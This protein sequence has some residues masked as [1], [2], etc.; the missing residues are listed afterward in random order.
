[1]TETETYL[2]VGLFGALNPIHIDEI[3]CSKTR[4]K[5]P[6]AVGLLVNTLSVH[7][8]QNCI[9]LCPSVLTTLD[10]T[11]I[12]PVYF[13]DTIRADVEITEINE[14]ENIVS[15]KHEM[16]NQKEETILVGKISLRIIEERKNA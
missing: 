3:Y 12:A 1:M 10:A 4:F 9:L 8:V 6:V 7:T 13:G 16:K 15:F 14:T 11:F 2:S 5:K